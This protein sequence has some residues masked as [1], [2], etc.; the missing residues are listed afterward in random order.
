MTACVLPD[1]TIK[2]F[3]FNDSALPDLDAAPQDWEA[4]VE[5][6][7][8]DSPSFVLLPDPF[9]FNIDNLTQ[10]LDYAF[11]N[12]VKLGGLASGANHAGANALFFQ[13][14]V[15]HE[16]VVGV[17]LHGNLQVDSLVAQGCRPIGSAFTI[18]GCSENYLVELDGMRAIHALKGVLDGLSERDQSLARNSLFLGIVMNEFQDDFHAG[19]FLIRNIMGIEQRTG[20]LVIGDVLN[21]GR[22]VPVSHSRCKKH[23]PT[24]C[25]NFYLHIL[26]PEIVSTAKMRRITVHCCSLVWGAGSVFTASL[27]MTVICFENFWVKFRLVVSFAMAKLD[28]LVAR[29]FYM[30][31]PHR[32]ASFEKRQLTKKR[33]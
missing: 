16:G 20:A 11:P 7:A 31:T 33:K 30:V 6:K 2:P 22:T 12:S 15:F 18:T 10:G 32:L 5:V 21:K 13:D 8:S 26:A 23:L 24:I 27:I 19:D 28:P 1:V 4:L 17:S 3:H 9:G 14:Q 25:A 29:H